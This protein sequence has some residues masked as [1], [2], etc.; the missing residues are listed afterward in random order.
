MRRVIIA[1]VLVSAAM[2]ALLAAGQLID[3]GVFNL[4]IKAL[5]TDT[6]ASV[7]GVASLL[8]EVAAA[9]AITWR[10]SRTDRRRWTWF[11]LG[12]LVAALVLFRGLA[13]FDAATLAAPLACV[14]L[15]VCWLTWP[16]PRAARTV[17]WAALVLM[18]TS[19]ALHQVGEAADVVNH[20]GYSWSYQLVTV[21][22]HGCELAG[23]LL[24]ATGIIAGIEGRPVRGTARA[25]NVAPEMG[26]FTP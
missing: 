16:D 24:V 21:A 22:K 26:S 13:S 19:L 9:A 23:W 25:R 5:N 4:R 7:F 11:A 18:A 14:L 10:A 12:A 15:L 20:S 3:Y 6:H 2:F 8:A 1:G 17:V